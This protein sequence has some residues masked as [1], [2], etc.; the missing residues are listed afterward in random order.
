MNV[1][2]VSY[3][4]MHDELF[5]MFHKFGKHAFVVMLCAHQDFF[6]PSCIF[7]KK[8]LYILYRE[9]IYFTLCFTR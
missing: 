4:A 6:N 7:L 8:M 2:E 1:D 9:K 3:F 5:G